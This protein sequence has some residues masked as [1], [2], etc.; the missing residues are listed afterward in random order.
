[1][2][3]AIH[4]WK[5]QAEEVSDLWQQ[6]IGKLQR[7]LKDMNTDPTIIDDIVSG[8]SSWYNPDDTNI[9]PR[10]QQQL[11]QDMIGWKFFVEG[12]LSKEWRRRQT[13]FL[14]NNHKRS[15]V[16]R[17]IS[18]LILKV[19]EVAWDLW[20]HRNGVEHQHDQE[21]LHRKLDSQILIEV[22]QHIIGEYPP[23]DFMFSANEIEKLK[24]STIGYKKAWLRNV[25]GARKQQTRHRTRSGLRGMQ[26]TMRRF[27]GL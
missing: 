18:A 20:E 16:K 9:P 22:D 2:E 13:Q 14:T 3:T 10:N 24:N 12:W 1:M 5:C 27:L 23:M 15:S 21:E 26:Q 25:L 6:S 4:V 7:H 19:W 8:L 17:W 11:G